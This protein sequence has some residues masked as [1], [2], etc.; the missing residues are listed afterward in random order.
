MAEWVDFDYVKQEVGIAAIL[1]HYGLLESM[2]Q[3]KGDELKGHCP[4]HDDTEPSFGANT[5]KNNF[6]CFGGGCDAKG[7][8][9]DFVRLKERIDTGERNQGRRQAALLIQRWF[10]LTSPR[11]ERQ[12][13]GNDVPRQ[14]EPKEVPV[15]EVIGEAS[16]HVLKQGEGRGERAKEEDGVLVNPPLQFALKHLDHTHPYL[17]ERGLTPETIETFGVGFQPGKGIMSGR[18]VIPVHNEQGELV[19]YAGRWPGDEGWPEGEGK[20][21]L[22]PKF[23]KSL[24]VYNLHRVGESL[25]TEGLVI[26]EGFFDV[27]WLWQAGVMNAVA[28][29][30]SVISSEQEHL[31][32]D[33][34]GPRGKVALM[35][36]KDEAGWR[37]RELAL[38]RLAPQVY[39]K[40][41]DLG[42]D[43]RQPD[44]LSGEV[45]RRLL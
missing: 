3:K 40:V 9:I 42:E 21:K 11:R 20:Y 39:V 10:S 4:F 45:I 28:L 5:A 14:D 29:M 24:V 30:G 38:A 23:Q 41:I 37:C 19:A 18:I 33:A 36:D 15:I 12:R 1:S 16:T 17:V 34:V 7:D 26:C 6:N 32:V 35:F 13:V 22:P 25:G 44:R 27:M 31:I 2:T 8:V 43:G